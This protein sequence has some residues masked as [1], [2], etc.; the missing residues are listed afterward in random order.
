MNSSAGRVL[1]QP[2]CCRR[3]RRTDSAERDDE[4]IRRNYLASSN[5]P[6]GTGARAEHFVSAQ[7]VCANSRRPNYEHNRGLG[8][9]LPLNGAR[10]R[11]FHRRPRH[12]P[13]RSLTRASTA[14]F[15]AGR[16]MNAL[17]IDASPYPATAVPLSAS[18]WTSPE[19]SEERHVVARCPRP[20][21]V[22]LCDAPLRVF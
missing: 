5:C 6:A 15:E 19:G 18:G 22:L 2:G 14:D 4:L 21:S 16:R 20:S 13:A 7:C 8:T 11:S 1:E 3:N 17:Q 9:W 12:P 10:G